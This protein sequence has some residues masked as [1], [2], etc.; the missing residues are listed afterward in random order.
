VKLTG[1]TIAL[2]ALMTTALGT[3]VA[4]I[5]SYAQDNSATTT[6]DAAAPT[7]TAMIRIGP[8][9]G[10]PGDAMFGMVA[11]A[12]A[13]LEQ[14]DTNGDGAISQDEIDAQRAADLAQYDT[15][16][17]G[18]LSLEEYQAY[19]MARFYERM[20]DAF[21]QLDANG[22]GEITADEFNAGLANIVARLDQNGDGV[23]NADD[24]AAVQ[25][26]RQDQQQDQ[27]PFAGPGQP[28]PGQFGPGQFGPGGGPHR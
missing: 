6:T 14:F 5:P 11:H 27:R 28:G 24:R 8:H 13:L 7:D 25:Q 21:Q 4:V 12:E 19:W 26:Q 23:L 18:T 1:K 3:A 15:N 16:G 17:D 2:A 10:G 9:T 20:V 22:D